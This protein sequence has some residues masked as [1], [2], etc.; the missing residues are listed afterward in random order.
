[1]PLPIVAHDKR[2]GKKVTIKDLASYKAYMADI[3]W[4]LT[5]RQDPSHLGNVE[6][7]LLLCNMI[8]TYYGNQPQVRPCDG[9][10]LDQRDPLSLL[11]IE[12]E[13]WTSIYRFF[14]PTT[15]VPPCREDSVDDLIICVVRLAEQVKGRLFEMLKRPLEDG[16][17]QPVLPNLDWSLSENFREYPAYDMNYTDQTLTVDVLDARTGFKDLV[18]L[19]RDTGT[20]DI[21]KI[22]QGTFGTRPVYL[23]TFAYSE[24]RLVHEK[25]VYRRIRWYMHHSRE[26]ERIHKHFIE[27]LVFIQYKEMDDWR[28]MVVTEDT[29]ARSVEAVHFDHGF[30]PMTFLAMMLQLCV[31]VQLLQSMQMIHQD[32]HIGNIIAVPT[33]PFTPELQVN[34]T[35]YTSESPCDYIA[36]VYDFD[37]AA[38]IN[39][40]NPGLD[41]FCHHVGTCN[42]LTSQKDQFLI[43]TEL[44]SLQTRKYVTDMGPLID[45]MSSMDREGT[46][47]LG[48][49]WMYNHRPPVKGRPEDVWSRFCVIANDKF[50]CPELPRA[51]LLELPS[52]ASLI[53]NQQRR[54]MAPK[55]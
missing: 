10:S 50:R 5:W 17:R 8:Y 20:R 53:I 42:D 41:F 18:L 52:L 3:F 11:R 39:G 43:W 54:M 15:A 35:V 29:G 7:A 48:T 16:I 46:E 28:M 37:H 33:R 32:F 47:T 2:T 27:P 49:L 34:G 13:T 31:I 44:I 55:V 36:K 51:H 9:V 21:A 30:S 4:S 19:S 25:E 26:K 23:K 12:K 1:M 6:D 14:Y 40:E 24:K 22:Y 38:M 45:D